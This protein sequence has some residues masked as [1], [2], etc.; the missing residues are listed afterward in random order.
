MNGFRPYQPKTETV[1]AFK[2]YTNP[3]TDEVVD[4]FDEDDLD[5][6]EFQGTLTEAIAKIENEIKASAADKSAPLS[7]LRRLKNIREELEEKARS[8]RKV[9]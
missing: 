2:I 1:T 4:Y 7:E 3:T 8:G 5:V 6:W 9:K